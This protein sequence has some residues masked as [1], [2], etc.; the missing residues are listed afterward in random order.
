MDL[1]GSLVLLFVWFSCFDL[2]LVRA[3]LFGSMYLEHLFGLCGLVW[4]FRAL[5]WFGIHLYLV[6]LIQALVFSEIRLALVMFGRALGDLTKVQI[7]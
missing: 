4:E 6:R 1:L 7:C 2:S 5:V 3:Y